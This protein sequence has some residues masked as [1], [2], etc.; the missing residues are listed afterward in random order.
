MVIALRVD[1]SFSLLQR[2]GNQEGEQS[3]SL[4]VTWSPIVED[5][6]VVPAVAGL[7][8]KTLSNVTVLCTVNLGNPR[9]SLSDVKASISEFILSDQCPF[10]CV[11]K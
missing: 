4:A 11:S 7:P 3:H 9:I 2:S 1:N 5:V 10:P 8:L 6:K